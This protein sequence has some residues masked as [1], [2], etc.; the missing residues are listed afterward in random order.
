MLF[1]QLSI[2]VR[3]PRSQEAKEKISKSLR[4]R[5]KPASHWRKISQTL[6][7][8]VQPQEAKKKIAKWRTGRKHNVETCIQISASVKEKKQ[9]TKKKFLQVT[10]NVVNSKRKHSIETRQKMAE[11]KRGKRLSEETKKKIREA[12]LKRST[13]P[14]NQEKKPKK[15]DTILQE[16]LTDLQNWKR[17]KPVYH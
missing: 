12:A 15:K 4:G 11:S 16:M 9:Q 6:K 3:W 5:E 13:R 8:R 17:P 14:K 10:K 2:M 1:L 7:G